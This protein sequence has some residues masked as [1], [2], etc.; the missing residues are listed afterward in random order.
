MP[1]QSGSLEK[2]AKIIAEAGRG[3]IQASHHADEQRIGRGAFRNPKI[4]FH[5]GTGF[6]HDGADDATGH[7][8]TA[9]D[10]RQRQLRRL[11]RRPRI[12]H[13]LRPAR[14]EQMNVGIDDRDRGRCG[15]GR[16]SHCRRARQESPALHQCRLTLDTRQ[17]P[18][19]AT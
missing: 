14:I 8:K 11:A 12:W 4:V 7:G 15:C 6:N 2:T 13:A 10:L 5:P 19:S 16:G 1:R 3:R 9:I 17:L 18:A